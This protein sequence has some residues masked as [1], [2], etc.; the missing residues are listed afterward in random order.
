VAF[1]WYKDNM[2]IEGETK[3]YIYITPTLDYNATYRALLTRDDGVSVMTCGLQP[4]TRTDINVVP[5]VTMPK[6]VVRVMTSQTS[7]VVTVYNTT[8]AVVSRTTINDMATDIVAPAEQG[9]YIMTVEL[10]DGT[11]ESFKIIVKNQ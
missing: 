8:G 6:N 3:S 11:R 4:Q 9:L 1:Q 5:T 2:P 10:A 7:G